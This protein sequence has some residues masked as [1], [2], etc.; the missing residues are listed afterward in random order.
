M[1]AVQEEKARYA[2]RDPIPRL[3]KQLLDAGL[4]SEAELKAIE[5]RV[6]DEVGGG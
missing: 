2:A 1:C 6:T 5:K 3:R 4:A